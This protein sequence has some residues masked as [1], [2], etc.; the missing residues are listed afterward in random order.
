M[1]SWE[2]I[3]YERSIKLGVP[4]EV[5]LSTIKAETGGKNVA[6]G[7]TGNALG[8]GQVY[9]K[10]WYKELQE[11]AKSWG[12]SLPGNTPILKSGS[13][14][15]FDKASEELVKGKVLSDDRL[16]LDWAVR[17]I[18]SVWDSSEGDY[19]TFVKKY[20]GPAVPVSEIQRRSMYLDQYKKSLPIGKS[21]L[22]TDLANLI[23]E[24]D[25]K[26]AVAVGVLVLGIFS[27]LN[28]N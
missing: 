11:T 26:K 27:L 18:K 14:Y 10:W 5:V 3:A 9:L 13:G 1:T 15:V 28:N 21:D 2:Q 19:A 23:G 4:P 25:T 16:S 20:V 22:T 6:G 8:F 12:I 7:S 24:V 17:V